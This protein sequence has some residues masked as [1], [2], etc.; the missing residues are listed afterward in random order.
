MKVY[1]IDEINSLL[2]KVDVNLIGYTLNDYEINDYYEKVLLKQNNNSLYPRSFPI[3]D[4]LNIEKDFKDVGLIISVGLSYN[5]Q[6]NNDIFYSKINYNYDYHLRIK[7]VQEKIIN[8]LQ[9]LDNNLKYS[10]SCD[11]KPLDDRYFAYLCGLGFYGK[12][13]LLINEQYG[14]NVAYGTIITNIKVKPFKVNRLSSLCKECNICEKA[15][16]SQA[17]INYQVIY[18]KCLSYLTQS[19]ELFD[20]PNNFKSIYGCDIC[21]NVCPFNQN[22]LVKNSIEPQINLNDFLELS[23]KEIKDIYRNKSFL[24]LNITILK[25]NALLLA[26]KK[27]SKQKKEELLVL[28][29][30]SNSD[31]IK[32]TVEYLKKDYYKM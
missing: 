17:L 8:I 30:N 32:K 27:A 7:Q 1:N 4:Y 28:Y 21:S 15:C 13:S 10:L 19:K 5:Y 12:N 31:L 24:W 11:T 25:K 26:Y 14:C 2:E 22:V 23:K 6:V 3:S 29:S 9:N 20:F 16:P 18:H